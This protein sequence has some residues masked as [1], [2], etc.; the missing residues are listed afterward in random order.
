MIWNRIEKSTEKYVTEICL[1]YYISK[2]AYFQVEQEVN[3]SWKIYLAGD[4]V[5]EAISGEVSNLHS[6]K[7]DLKII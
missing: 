6:K 7:M 4:T 5:R 2:A 1:K 3:G